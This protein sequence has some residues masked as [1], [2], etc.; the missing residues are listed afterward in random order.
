[1]SKNDASRVYELLSQA[2]EG[3][4]I[5]ARDDQNEFSAF[6]DAAKACRRRGRRFRLIDT[7]RFSLFHLEW[8][9]KAGADIYTGDEARP[10]PF[11]INLL[12]KACA[13]G[14]AIAAYLHQGNLNRGEG[15]GAASLAVLL[16]IGRSGAYL[17]LSN[18]EK[19]RD[20]ADLGELAY[21]C[22][23]AG[24]WLVYYHHG[25]P[26]AGL[27]EPARNGAWI[28]LA[29]QSLKSVA[30]TS[31]LFEVIKKTSGAGANIVLHV[32]T[33]VAVETL[34]DLLD[35]G[36]HLLFKTPPSDYRSAFRRL[37]AR[38]RKRKL[39]FRAYYLHTA[40]ML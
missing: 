7:G 32:E 12:V 36:A 19:K 22:R 17:Y 8:L 4:E 15:S 28:H 26:E 35:F 40:F 3:L 39:D 5:T 1:M 27:A 21:A 37:E 14:R 25:H 38:A 18:R 34:L 13:E 30:D 10:D 29:D 6:L 16:E 24:T 20:V 9:G 11:E 33:G 31:L 23:Q 2:E